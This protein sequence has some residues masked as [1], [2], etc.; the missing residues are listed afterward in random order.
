MNGLLLVVLSYAAG[1]SDLDGLRDAAEHAA[2]DVARARSEGARRAEIAERMKVYRAAAEALAAAEAGQAPP[3]G[4]LA[5]LAAL[6]EALATGKRGEEPRAAVAAALGEPAE[7][8]PV[9]EEGLETSLA[10]GPGALRS[11]LLRDLADQADGLALIATWDAWVATQEQRGVEARLAAIEHSAPGQT[12][13][14]DRAVE[15]QRLRAERDGLAARADEARALA[16]RARSV[17]ERATE[18]ER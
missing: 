13:G 8:L 7:R 17:S 3:D 5:A 2:A 11:S 6:T 10:L 1:G 18:D 14:V 9:L 12:G 16:A 4:P 15:V